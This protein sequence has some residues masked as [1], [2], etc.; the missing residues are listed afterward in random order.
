MKNNKILFLSASLLV[1]MAMVFFVSGS[2]NVFAQ[3]EGEGGDSS[4][5]TSVNGSSSG[6]GL[7]IG[8]PI[9]PGLKVRAENENK[10]QTNL[11]EAFDAGSNSSP[12]ATPLSMSIGPQGQ[13]RITNGSVTAVNGNMLTVSVFGVNFSVD[14]SNA[15][16]VG[17]TALPPIPNTATSSA[18]STGTTSSTTSINVGDKVVV[19][20]TIDSSTGIIKANTI[21]NLS[22]QVQ[23]NSDIA[24]RINQ[25]LQMINQLR[26]QLGM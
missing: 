11:N 16:I 12:D 18:T 26:A 5:A 6:F 22:A 17:A 23:S 3:N 8:T 1:I 24:N 14:S 25:L 4:S 19:Q 2:S 10:V 20:G 21:R 13:A 15:N 9:A 7:G